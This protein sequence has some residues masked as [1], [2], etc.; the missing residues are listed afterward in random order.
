MVKKQSSNKTSTLASKIL[1][2]TKKPTLSDSKKLAGSVLSQDEKKGN[3]K[4]LWDEDDMAEAIRGEEKPVAEGVLFGL[5]GGKLA[6]FGGLAFVATLVL[7]IL[8]LVMFD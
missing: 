1:S 8:W 7:I 5:S 3:K 6:M 4:S 2:G